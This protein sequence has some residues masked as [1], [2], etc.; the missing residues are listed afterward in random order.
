M[1]ALSTGVMSAVKFPITTLSAFEAAFKPGH[2][3]IRIGRRQLAVIEGLLRGFTLVAR[4]ILLHLTAI[5]VRRDRDVTPTAKPGMAGTRAG[6]L[7]A[8][9]EVTTYLLA[10]EAVGVVCFRTALRRGV[11]A[12]ETGL[13]RAHQGARRTRACVT[14]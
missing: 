10:A 4:H 5:A 1:T 12:T 7:T 8:R 11:F 2:G 9:Q 13:S 3:R 14:G 6:M